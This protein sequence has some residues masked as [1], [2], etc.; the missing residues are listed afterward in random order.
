MFYGTSI[1]LSEVSYK[2]D[3]HFFLYSNFFSSASDKA[4]VI[5]KRHWGSWSNQF[6][7]NFFVQPFIENIGFFF[8]FYYNVSILNSWYF[9][10]FFCRNLFTAIFLFAP[11]AIWWG[12]W[13][14]LSTFFIYVSILLVSLFKKVNLILILWFCPLLCKFVHFSGNLLVYDF[15]SCFSSHV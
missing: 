13:F 6:C 3:K 2:Y 14:L 8:F 4:I 12:F 11:S 7:D 1:F 15:T 5:R 10:F 9:L